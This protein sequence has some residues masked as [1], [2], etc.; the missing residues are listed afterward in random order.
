MRYLKKLAWF[1]SVI[2]LGI[3]II[4]CDSSSDT[5]EKA[6]EDS[7][8][9]QIK[10]SFAKTL[11]M[12]PI[13]N[14]EDLYDE[15]GYRD[16]EFK[17]GDKGMWTIY[18]DFAKSNKPGVLDNEGMILNLDRN[19]RT[20][21]GYYFVDTIYDNHENSYS[22]NYR[23]E[24]KN[25]KIILLDKV[26]DQKLKERIE[27][28]KFFG[29]YAD[30][31]SLKSYN[32]GDVS[33]N[34]NVP[35]YDAKFKMSNKDENVKQL[36]SRYNIPTEKAPILKMHI[37]GDLKGSSVGYKKLEI[38]FSKEENSELSVVDSLNFQPAKKNKDDE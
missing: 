19:T 2:I 17:K 13:K 18:T 7:K 9:E 33:I 22:K 26:E 15:E 25:N 24:M 28:F 21:K 8:E 14:L 31:K 34:S 32:N 6:K 1:I 16:S 36:R 3:F 27:N 30:F 37:D 38:D 20:A 4:G 10:K 12:Y 11:D 23:V 29:Q 35:S 5:G